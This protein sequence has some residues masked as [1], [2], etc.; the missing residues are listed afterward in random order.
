MG[1]TKSVE[2][3]VSAY[4]VSWVPG[5]VTGYYKPENIKDIDAADLRAKLLP[6]KF[7]N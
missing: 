1:P 6:K 5:P 2:D 3:G 7:K 4:K